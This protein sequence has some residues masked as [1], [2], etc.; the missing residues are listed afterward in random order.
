MAATRSM[1]E[2]LDLPYAIALSRGDGEDPW[3]AQV[4]DLPGCEARGRTPEEAAA[5]VQE[6]MTDWIGSALAEGRAV[7]TPRAELSGR[8]PVRTQPQL[9]ADLGPP[10]ARE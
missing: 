8:L 7:P 10:P 9:P 5:R 3:M 2:Y 1:E 4:D 6:A